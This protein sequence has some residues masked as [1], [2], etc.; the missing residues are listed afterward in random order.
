MEK[1]LAFYTG[2]LGL[3]VRSDRPD[4]GFPGAWLDAGSQQ[5]HLIGAPLPL[6]TGGS[7]GALQV[8]DLDAAISELRQGGVEVSDPVPVGTNRQAFLS[9]PAG[10]KIELHQ[11]APA[12]P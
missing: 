7:I 12:R 9:D 5:V 3:V 8:T 11:V 6:Q 4:F 2:P 10:N 1:A